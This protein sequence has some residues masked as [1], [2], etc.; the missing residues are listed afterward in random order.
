MKILLADFNAK[1]RREDIFKPTTGNE[2]LHESS[3]DIG[4]TVVIFA[5]SKNLIVQSTMFPHRNIHKFV[6]ASPDGKTQNQIVHILI[7]RRRHSS[8]LDVLSFTTIWC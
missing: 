4:V 2:S 5:K 7:D 8:I 1:V 3:N 6:W